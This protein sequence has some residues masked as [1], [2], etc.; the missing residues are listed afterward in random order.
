MKNVLSLQWDDL[1]TK[2]FHDLQKHVTQRAPKLKKA[3]YQEKAI[4][5]FLPYQF[6]DQFENIEAELWKESDKNRGHRVVASGLRNR[7]VLLHITMG[8][9]RCESL[10]RAKLSDFCGVIV[11]PNDRDAH[12]M[13]IMV[14]QIPFGKTNHGRVLYGRATR[15]K[16]VKL[17]PIA[18]FAFY[19]QYRF[20]VTDE[21]LDFTI[22]DWCDN[23][24][25]FDIKLLVDVAT[26]D[27]TLELANDQ[28]ARKL[29]EVLQRLGLPMSILVHFGR[30]LGP[31]ILDLLEEESREIERLGNWNPSIQDGCYSTKLPLKPIRK[32]AGY[33]GNGTSATRS[34]GVTIGHG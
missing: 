11:P 13:F 9:L 33:G 18:A 12:R 23:K 28:Y 32:M 29:K 14:N 15:H 8:I 22:E 20:H 7:Y 1:W 17:C 2:E 21:F 24:K 19:L 4:A 30:K 31:R 27:N 5:E 10:Y 34:R 6:V 16:H 25:W 3:T 26:G